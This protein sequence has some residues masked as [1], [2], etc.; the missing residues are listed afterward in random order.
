MPLAPS[1]AYKAPHYDSDSASSM[2][3]EAGS[4]EKDL[5]ISSDDDMDLDNA[6]FSGSP[7]S[8]FRTRTTLLTSSFSRSNK[9]RVPTP[10]FPP[11]PDIT[12]LQTPARGRSDTVHQHMRHR[13]PATGSGEHLEVPSP[14]DEDEVPTPPS[15]AEIAGSQLEMLS[16]SDM[17]MEDD[18]LPVDPTR[19]LQL[20]DHSDEPMDSGPGILPIRKTRARSGALSNG[21]SREATPTAGNGPRGFSMGF[22]ADCEKCRLRVPGHMTHFLG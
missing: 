22:R 3:S 6:N 21:V 5:P 12:P 7:G 18:P 1:T 2:I 20:N 19:S 13:H 14:I 17:D 10:M 9:E 4:V 15:A 11:R 8:P 16:V